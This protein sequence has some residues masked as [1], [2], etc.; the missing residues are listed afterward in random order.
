MNPDDADMDEILGAFTPADL[1]DRGLAEVDAAVERLCAATAPRRRR[2]R[3]ALAVGAVLAAL[4]LL[5]LRPAPPP[6]AEPPPLP[7][8]IALAP[9]P[10]VGRTA[11][12]RVP[13]DRPRPVRAAPTA[14]RLQPGLLLGRRV[15]IAGGRAVLAGGTLGYVHDPTHEP[16]V[17]QVALG[18][19]P[20]VLQPVGTAF[21]A[22]V[23]SDDVAA[24][25]VAEGVVLVVHDDGTLLAR[26]GPG[27]EAVTVTDLAAPL[28]VR[29]V[30]TTGL[31]LDAVRA[32]IP[33]DCPCRPRDVVAAVASLRLLAM[34]PTP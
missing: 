10:T 30:Q 33:V 21:T 18:E 29:L 26:L 34:A 32:Q 1:A 9:P 11:P 4:A 17:R 31:P 23:R 14:P 22:T 20:V 3:A 7:S 5:A 25:R 6:A 12:A 2:G 27:Q 13:V 16:G 24:L 8:A 19:L 15:T 28:G